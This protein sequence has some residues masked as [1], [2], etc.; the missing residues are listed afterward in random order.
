[1]TRVASVRDTQAAMP[2]GPVSAEAEPPARRSYVPP[3]IV[4]SGSVD[5]L[6]ELLGPA[7][8]NYSGPGLP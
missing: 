4:D 6:L 5:Y 3:A 8:A 1:M 7:Q 2:A